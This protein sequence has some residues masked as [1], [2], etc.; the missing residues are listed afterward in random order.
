MVL[1]LEEEEEDDEDELEEEEKIVCVVLAM[2]ELVEEEEI[3]R[4]ESKDELDDDP[5]SQTGVDTVPD[6]APD[7]VHEARLEL[8][9]PLNAQA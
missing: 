5:Q 1:E 7:H 3:C 8:E 6:D 4:W 9:E 2:E